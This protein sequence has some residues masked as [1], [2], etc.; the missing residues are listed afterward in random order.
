MAAD[1]ANIP[2]RRRSSPCR[3]FS[4]KLLP[5]NA[6]IA[7]TSAISLQ[8]RNHRPVS[9]S[10]SS[11]AGPS[12]RYHK[13]YSRSGGT[14][15]WFSTLR[16]STLRISN[17]RLSTPTFSRISLNIEPSR[18]TIMQLDDFEEF[19]TEAAGLRYDIPKHARRLF[20]S[21]PR[22]DLSTCFSHPSLESSNKYRGGEISCIEE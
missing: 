20:S 11:L 6:S 14:V 15:G 1:K 17:H 16:R 12:K 10:C 5:G 8:D 22:V 21:R 4:L 3:R 9:P 13:T 18:Q 7:S 19:P 2:Q